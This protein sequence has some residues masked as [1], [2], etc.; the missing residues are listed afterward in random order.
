MSSRGGDRYRKRSH[1]HPAAAAAAGSS[2]HTTVKKKLSLVSPFSIFA[3]Q[4]RGGERGAGTEGGKRPLALILSS[5]HLLHRPF[6]LLFCILACFPS[7]SLSSSTST[8][9]RASL[10]MAPVLS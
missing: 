5:A 8:T 2:R 7:L 9:A 10:K 3:A 1:G 4:D 6:F